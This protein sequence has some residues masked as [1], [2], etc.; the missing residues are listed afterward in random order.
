MS[1]TKFHGP[2]DVRTIEVRLYIYI[3][4]IVNVKGFNKFH[5]YYICSFVSRVQ[6]SDKIVNQVDK[7]VVTKSMLTVSKDVSEGKCLSS[8]STPWAVFA[9]DKLIIFFL[10]ENSI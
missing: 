6:V 5:D 9:D 1:R 7:L 3:W 10:T 4:N 2:K 8:L